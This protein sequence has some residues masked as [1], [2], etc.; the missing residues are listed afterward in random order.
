MREIG[1]LQSYFRME[2]KLTPILSLIS[3]LEINCWER[4]NN[5]QTGLLIYAPCNN[6]LGLVYEGEKRF[7]EG[8][9]NKKA[10]YLEIKQAFSKVF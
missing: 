2:I 6:K 3:I 7:P 5:I 9:S 8:K 1:T 4:W 10:S